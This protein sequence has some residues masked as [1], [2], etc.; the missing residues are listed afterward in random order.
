MVDRKY[1][2][3]LTLAA[4]LAAPSA[5]AKLRQ[6][7]LN[8]VRFEEQLGEKIPLDAG[9]TD[10]KG[11]AGRL[12]E[13][14]GGKPAV[15][16]FVDYTCDNT[17]GTAAVAL[18]AAL[19]ESKLAPGKEYSA[20][21]IG[22]DPTDMPSTARTMKR[23]RL[24]DDE[25][26]KSI[27]FLVGTPEGTK[28]LMTAAGVHVVYDEQ[29]DLYAHPLGFVVV[30]GGG[31]VSRYLAGAAVNAADLRQA[32]VEASQNTIGTATD[33]LRSVCYSWSAATGS[34]VVSPP[35]MA[36]SL[37]GATLLFGGIALALR[38]GRRHSHGAK[39]LPASA[40]R[41]A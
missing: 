34:Y 5:D 27:R 21:V 23:E 10:E 39:R 19:R 14:I 31:T 33:R 4:A 29:R 28:A 24:G 8:E 41:R 36:G 26:S 7:E 2:A 16:L 18:A 15:L 12:A 25:A 40:G 3:V 9:F 37:G 13:L 38:Q 1:A 35:I 6:A 20:L 22:V 11:K 17:C 32:L 30:T